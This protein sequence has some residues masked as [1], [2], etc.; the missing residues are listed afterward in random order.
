MSC[1]SLLLP[2]THTKLQAHQDYLAAVLLVPGR[3]SGFW[4]APTVLA[5]QQLVE[6]RDS[7]ESVNAAQ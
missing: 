3:S 1:S 5:C 2:E 4:P 6:H 7:F